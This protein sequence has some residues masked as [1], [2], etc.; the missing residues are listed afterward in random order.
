[1]AAASSR[2]RE[3]GWTVIE[4]DNARDHGASRQRDA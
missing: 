3:L 4:I 1:V 2:A